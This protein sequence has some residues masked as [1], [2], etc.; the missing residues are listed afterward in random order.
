[1]RN[2]QIL[3]EAGDWFVRMR[4]GEDSSALR[5]EFMEWLRRSPEHV[6]AYLD[7]AAVWM[8]AKGSRVDSELE[9]S[10]RIATAKADK[11]V[12][13]IA[14]RAGQG[15]IGWRGRR[16]MLALV[17][18]V[19]LV[20]GLATAWWSFERFTYST[21]VG[22]L[23]SIALHDGST[24]EL[25]SDSRVRVRLDDR[26]RSIQLLHGQALFHVA[27]DRIRPFIV[28]AD[29]TAVRA[30]GTVFDV[31]RKR[32][33][34]IV[35]VVEGTVVVERRHADASTRRASEAADTP[36]RGSAEPTRSGLRLT[37]GKQVVVDGHAAERPRIVNVATATAW[38]RRELVFE[39][40]PLSE[41]AAEF[42]RYNERQ[43]VVEGEALR[44]FKITAMFRSTD[45]G[46]L[47]RYMQAMPGV[48]IEESDAAVII[49]SSDP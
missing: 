8:E 18:S 47:I 43:L 12:A 20:A 4:E 3:D 26:Q 32:G 39:F 11:S 22:E 49:R 44:N 2:R 38:T 46:S 31:Y 15:A 35:T 24:I 33:G 17:A 30:V 34:A 21:D 36:T 7:I 16:G 29:D 10:Q 5:T 14:S 1:M 40:T 42:N 41:A 28:Y 25:N 19:L 37:A 13:E 23:R 6:S 9:V 27:K 48:R 45:A